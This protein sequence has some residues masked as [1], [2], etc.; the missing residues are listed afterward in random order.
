MSWLPISVDQPFKVFRS[1]TPALDGRIT[2]EQ[3]RVQRVHADGLH[4]PMAS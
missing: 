1:G 3:G 4:Q 2:G